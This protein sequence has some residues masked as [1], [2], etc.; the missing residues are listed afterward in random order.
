MVGVLASVVPGYWIDLGVVGV[1]SWDSVRSFSVGSTLVCS[2]SIICSAPTPV[3]IF[4]ASLMEDRS[5]GV[6]SKAPGLD[7]A[8]STT[9]SGSLTAVLSVAES[10]FWMLRGRVV[11]LSTSSRRGGGFG[12]LLGST[13]R[14]GRGRW[15]LMVHEMVPVAGEKLRPGQEVQQDWKGQ[16]DSRE[17][18]G[19]GSRSPEA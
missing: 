11:T 18:V 16:L 17:W 15:I 3:M 19:R 9:C 8:F 10:R 12:A 5:T 7:P 13:G 1:A 6:A 2:C 14:D 4:S